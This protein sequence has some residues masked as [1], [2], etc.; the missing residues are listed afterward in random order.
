MKSFTTE[1]GICVTVMGT[2]SETE[3]QVLKSRCGALR[4]TVIV[5]L[6][7]KLSFDGHY[8]DGFAYLDIF[9]DGEDTVEVVFYKKNYFS[10]HLPKKKGVYFNRK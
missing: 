4:S 9:G 8:D 3:M 10:K 7:N 2:I 6:Q 5:E 1:K